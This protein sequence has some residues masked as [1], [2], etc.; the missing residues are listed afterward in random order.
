ML[1]VY[2][3]IMMVH[4]WL[5]PYKQRKL[6]ILDSSIL[7][8][9]ILVFIGEHASYDST[10]ALWILPLILFINCVAFSSRLKYILIPV[11]C[12]G[13]FSFSFFEEGEWL[14]SPFV[15]DYEY[16]DNYGDYVYDYDDDDNFFHSFYAINFMIQLISS[17][18]L[19][20]YIIYVLK[21]LGVAVKK[22]CHKPEYRLINGPH[23]NAYE[24]SDS[25]EEF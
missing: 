24:G 11:S 13:I 8:T 7:M 2:I 5:Q 19:L 15:L 9:L 21:C 6:N 16:D 17:L 20:A 3:L 1:T 18:A 10:L 23:E 25:N 4:V 22:R 14:P 12:L